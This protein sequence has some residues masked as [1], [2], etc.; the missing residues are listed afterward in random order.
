MIFQAMS[1]YVA[2]AVGCAVTGTDV[3]LISSGEVLSVTCLHL[4]L[5]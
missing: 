4:E 1:K 3:P 5:L 2:V